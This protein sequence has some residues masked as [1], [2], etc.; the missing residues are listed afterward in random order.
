[1]VRQVCVP[2]V[3]ALMRV[4]LQMINAKTH[5]TR[6]EVREV[7]DDR[8]QFVP[9]W[10]PENQ[11]VR[12]VMDDHVI[13]MICE[14]ADAKRNQ[15]TEPPVTKSQTAHPIR[16]CRLQ[17]QDRD[18]EQSSPWIAHHQLANLGMRLDDRP[19]PPRMRLIRVRLVK[20]GLHCPPSYC[21][22]AAF[23]IALFQLSAAKQWQDEQVCQDVDDASSE[24][25]ETKP[26]R[27]R[28]I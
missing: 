4:M 27:R 6:R 20:R 15:Q 28:K 7:G 11:V 24:N 16:D 21:I 8:H 22:A 14:R 23:S 10:A 1:M 17:D 3:V 5:R 12:R 25:Y 13:G 2:F 26:L 9:A 18:R 19:R